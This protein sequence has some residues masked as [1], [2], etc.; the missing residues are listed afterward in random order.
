M[1]KT[2]RGSERKNNKTKGSKK[3]NRN[4]YVTKEKYTEKYYEDEE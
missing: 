4:K 1:G 2:Y 3:G